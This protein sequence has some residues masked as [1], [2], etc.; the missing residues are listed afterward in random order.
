MSIWGHLGSEKREGFVS[1]QRH[2][3]SSYYY[4]YCCC[5]AAA[6]AV[7]I[8]TGILLTKFGRHKEFSSGGP[9]ANW[10]TSRGG[11]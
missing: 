7:V 5:V 3:G 4:Y 6:V 9:L 1:F 11:L 10:V 2:N 8:Q